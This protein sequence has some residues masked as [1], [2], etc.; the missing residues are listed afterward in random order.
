MSSV[1]PNWI[2]IGSR[3]GHKSTVQIHPG[4]SNSI[5]QIGANIIVG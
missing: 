1:L 4:N 2:K 3:F 5:T